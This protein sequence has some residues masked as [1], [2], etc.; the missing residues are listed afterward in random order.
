MKSILPCILLFV[1]CCYTNNVFAQNV[2]TSKIAWQSERSLEMH[3][4]QD[5]IRYCTITTDPTSITL[6]YTNSKDSFTFSVTQVEGNWSNPSQAGSI[7]YH[8]T[9]QDVAGEIRI[10]RLAGENV[11]ITI[12]FTA[13]V[14][15]A[16]QQQFF[17]YDFEQR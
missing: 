12:D 10:A 9:Y 13:S 17:I 1:V 11:T 15:S 5:I 4:S 6:D 2:A 8:V 14:E 7:L 3:S 16:M